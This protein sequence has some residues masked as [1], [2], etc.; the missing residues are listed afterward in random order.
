MVENIINKKLREIKEKPILYINI[1][2]LTLISLIFINIIFKLD[3]NMTYTGVALVFIK[4]FNSILSILA[5]GSCLISYCRLKNDSV[6][7]ISLMYLVWLIDILLGHIDYLSFYFTEYTLS[8][9]LTI[10]TSLARVFLI[11]VAIIPRNK[12]KSIIVKNKTYSLLFVIG[13][14]VI[15]GLIENTIKVNNLYHSNFVFVNYNRMLI[16]VYILCSLKLFITGMK[17]KEYLFV[18]LS[19]SIS[20]LAIK[21]MIAIYGV[22]NISFYLKLVSV[23]ITYIS[24]L[25][26]ICGVFIELYMY[27]C[28][29][30]VLN[31][32]FKVFYDLFENN[33]YIFMFICKEDGEVLYANEKLRS[34]GLIGN[35]INSFKL[36][37]LIKIKNKS[38]WSDEVTT[39]LKDNGGWR[40]I[41]KDDTDN[42]TM[43]CTVQLIETDYENVISVSFMD[44]SDEIKRELELEKLK[45][46]DKSKNEFFSNISHELR[47]PL[48]IIY[49]TLQ[50]FNMYSK[51]ENVDFKKV[52][53]KY[54]RPL[55]INC[56]RMQRLINNIVDISKIE[57]KLL[58]ANFMNYDIINIVEELTLSVVEYAL[59]K[60]INIQ[61]DTNVEQ[62]I[63]KC[64]ASM[65]E[66]VILNLLSNAI[67]FSD[68]NK[69]I[70]VNILVNEEWVEIEVI[71]EGI[72]IPDISKQIIFEKFV[73]ADKSFTRMNEG[74]GIGLSII[75][76]LIDLHDGEI[77]LESEVNIG[78][79]FKI[80]LPNLQIESSEAKSYS[81]DKH[82][83]ELE[84]SDI[85]EVS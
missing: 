52:Y 6:F 28:R 16:I 65:I 72:G 24:F 57:S 84:L 32:N 7:I 17:E 9:Y 12:F 70:F 62:H 80:L 29:T 81:I 61:F 56:K 33:K 67:K 4:S 23:S 63:I 8:N 26:I 5:L 77:K 83:I 50:L 66:R 46:Y 42:I 64:D 47:T 2:M 41:I 11:I 71:D 55:D 73:Q 82:N 51:N 43:D 14:T 40:G 19:L 3:K 69:N 18:V 44:I 21:A 10:S 75:K 20:M 53:E 25:I 74:S 38:L 54:K 58:S 45:V 22:N 31:N 15:L 1:I 79:K 37:E 49:S 85:Y 27:I 13:Y 76:S 78:S 36:G 68:L 59:L 39:L 48:N 34:H 35:N 60:N 30:K